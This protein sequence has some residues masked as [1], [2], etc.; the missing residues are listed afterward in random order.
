MYWCWWQGFSH[1]CFNLTS[2]EFYLHSCCTWG[3]PK[4]TL[5]KARDKIRI[6]AVSTGFM[7]EKDTSAVS[8]PDLVQDNPSFLLSFV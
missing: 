8:W 1:G 7:E 6:S 4:A 3:L 2:G 5:S